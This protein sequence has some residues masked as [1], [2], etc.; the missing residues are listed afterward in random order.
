[1]TSTARPAF[2]SR[3]TIRTPREPPGYWQSMD[4]PVT[5]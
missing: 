3:R 1:M 2:V 5:P 4:W